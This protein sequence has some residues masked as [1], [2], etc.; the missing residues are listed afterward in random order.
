MHYTAVQHAGFCD[1]PGDLTCVRAAVLACCQC[2][3]VVTMSVLSFMLVCLCAQPKFLTK[4]ERAALALQRRQEE[5]AGVR[6]QQDEMRR[7][8]REQ[9]QVSWEAPGGVEDGC[10]LP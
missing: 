8:Q 3:T 10:G 9:Q 2:L 4:A 1:T 6:A 7:L 5:A